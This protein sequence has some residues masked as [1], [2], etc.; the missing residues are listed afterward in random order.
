MGPLSG[1]VD[2]SNEHF[3]GLRTSDAMYRFFGRNAFGVRVGMTVHG[4]SGTGDSAATAE[5]WSR[6]FGKVY[7]QGPEA[8]NI[9]DSQNTRRF[10]K[11]LTPWVFHVRQVFCVSRVIS[12]SGIQADAVSEGPA[13]GDGGAVGCGP[14]SVRR[15]QN[16]ASSGLTRPGTWRQIATAII[17]TGACNT[18]PRTGRAAGRGTCRTFP[19]ARARQAIAMAGAFLRVRRSCGAALSRS[20]AERKARTAVSSWSGGSVK[21]TRR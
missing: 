13:A 12:V 10:A 6:F 19:K 16:R 4:F 9:L 17:S 2:F 5:A 15:A 7:A 11:Y 3:L 21:G 1:E 8:G 14:V 20:W 18:V